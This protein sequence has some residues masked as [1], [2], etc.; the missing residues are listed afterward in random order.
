MHEGHLQTL[1]E[2]ATVDM[3]SALQDMDDTHMELASLLQ[4]RLQRHWNG[5]EQPRYHALVA[6]Q[7]SAYRRYQ[8]ARMWHQ[9]IRQ[10]IWQAKLGEPFSAARVPSTFDHT[11]RFPPEG[12]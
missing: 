1:L 7:R 4:V 2:R 5:D 12:L 10:Q 11:A 9:A 3:L 8:A 6:E